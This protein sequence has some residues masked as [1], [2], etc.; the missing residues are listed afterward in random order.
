[1]LSTV[2]F[3]SNV[4]TS[5][6]YKTIEQN[7]HKTPMTGSNLGRC[8]L[9]SPPHCSQ[10]LRKKEVCQCRLFITWVRNNLRSMASS[11]WTS[12]LAVAYNTRDNQQSGSHCIKLSSLPIWHYCGISTLDHGHT[13]FP[14]LPDGPWPELPFSFDSETVKLKPACDKW[15][16][17]CASDWENVMWLSVCGMPEIS[18]DVEKWSDVVFFSF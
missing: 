13:I 3:R 7:G 9:L 4:L 17:H 18:S 16:G 15:C 5:S 14:L 12:S 1:M 11:I 10:W 8:P 2:S 6:H